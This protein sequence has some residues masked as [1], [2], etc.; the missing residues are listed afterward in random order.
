MLD[1]LKNLCTLYGVSGDE[2]NIRNYILDQIKDKCECRIDNLGNV[3]AFKKG[4]KSS[5]RKLMIAAHMD[6]VGMIITHINNDGTLAFDVVGGIN[7]D[8]I[9]GRQVY[10]YNRKI[11]G[12]VSARAVHNMSQDD[13][14]KKITVSELYIDIGAKDAKD[15]SKVV[16]TGDYVS[17][18]SGYTQIG[19]GFVCSKAIDDRAGCAVMLDIIDKH[20]D[21]D[22]YFVFTVQEEIGLRGACVATYGICPDYALVI[23]TT[24]AADISDVS[25]AKRVCELGKG[26]VVSFMDKSTV[27]DR[28]MYEMAF[29]VSSENN[30]KC[31]T[32]TMIAGGN[33]S[34]AIHIS[35]SGV[36]TLSVSVPCRYL[37]S[38]SCMAKY[39]DIETCEL[40][41]DK[42]IPR[43]IEL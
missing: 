39:S 41:V 37:H 30:L 19:S 18:I 11:N 13:R 8:V 14:K 22:T 6:E 9:I 34:G 24:T 28:E 43:V 38:P 36:R 25:G 35:G 32:K 31:Q 1:H 17:F 26:A 42:L 23:E 15:A 10:I 2:R 21:Y 7:G 3:I 4:K 12:I 16:S 33:D 29:S 20:I 27:Y 40:L 5:A